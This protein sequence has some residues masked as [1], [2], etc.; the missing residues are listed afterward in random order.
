MTSR[1]DFSDA[2]NRTAVRYA[3]VTFLL[4][5]AAVVGAYI[6]QRPP[7]P[8]PASVPVTEFSA[9]RALKHI[10]A[11]ASETHPAGSFA[12]G[13]VCDYLLA[14]FK[15]MGVAAE[16]QTAVNLSG[17]G[18]YHNV[19]ARIPGTANTKAFALA[20]HHD[21]VPYGPGATDDCAGLGVMV[22]LARAVKGGPPLKNDIIFCFTDAEE[23][24]GG[25]AHA[26][27][28]HPWV[29][30]GEIGIILNFEARGTSGPS[31]MFETSPGNGWLIAEMA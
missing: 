2:E 1:N 10:R 29:K 14:Q 4:I 20:T 23:F 6:N 26:F 22:E 24:S 12:D 28:E 30:N 18:V 31:Y 17:V 11:V 8:K 5:L 9:E 13:R 16:L 25:G 21:S 19:V 27:T 15:E 3:T 7:S